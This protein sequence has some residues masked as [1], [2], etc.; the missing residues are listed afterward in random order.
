MEY[1]NSRNSKILIADENAASRQTLRDN[2]YRA[3]FRNVEE[4][5]NG[6]DA[7]IKIGRVHPDLAI[8]DVWLSKI[9]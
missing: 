1:N 5:S 3:G 9:D 8:I 7:L 6:E 2:L 4:A